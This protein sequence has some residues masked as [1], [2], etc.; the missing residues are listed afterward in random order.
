MAATKRYADMFARLADRGEG[1]FVPFTVLGDPDASQSLEIVRTLA[2]SGADALEL[3]L[4]FQIRLP[5]A[6]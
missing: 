5:M 4:P 3:V 1:A 2:Q 6:L